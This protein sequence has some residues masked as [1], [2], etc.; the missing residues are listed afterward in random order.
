MMRQQTKFEFGRKTGRKGW[1]D[2]ENPRKDIQF[3]KKLPKDLLIN[4]AHCSNYYLFYDEEKNE[5][6]RENVGQY[7]LRNAE[8]SNAIALHFVQQYRTE[9]KYRNL[10]RVRSQRGGNS[11]LERKSPNQ[12][13]DNN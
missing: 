2:P 8:I 6:E 12:T 9:E 1:L 5:R 3:G 11:I 13:F 4:Y 7:F 10:A